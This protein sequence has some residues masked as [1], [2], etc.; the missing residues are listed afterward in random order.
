[1]VKLDKNQIKNKTKSAFIDKNSKK[2]LWK[3]IGIW[4]TKQDGVHVHGLVCYYK[5]PP[6]T[7]CPSI[8][9]GIITSAFYTYTI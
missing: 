1:M 8:E 7:H 2:G 5:L 3:T 6:I 9:L 4:K